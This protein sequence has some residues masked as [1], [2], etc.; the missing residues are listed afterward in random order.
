MNAP[1]PTL[2]SIA[3][4]AWAASTTIVAAEVVALAL[5]YPALGASAL[6]ELGCFALA[7]GAVLGGAA[8]LVARV[9]GEPGWAWSVALWSGLALAHFVP[10]GRAGKLGLAVFAVAVLALSWVAARIARALGERLAVVHSARAWSVGSAAAFCALAALALTRREGAPELAPGGGKPRPSVLLVT[11]DTLRADFLGCY[12]REQARTPTLDGLAASGFRFEH[13]TAHTVLTGPSHASVLTGRLPAHHG[14]FENLQPLSHEVPTVAES[15]GSLGYRTGAF[16]AGYPLKQNAAA[17]LRRFEHYDDDFRSWRTLPS[18]AFELVLGHWMRLALER[19]GEHLDPHSRSASAVTEVASTWLDASD[20]RPF[21]AWVHYFD[22]HLPYEPPRESVPD[23]VRAYRGLDGADWYRLSP[24][25]RAHI[26]AD[27]AA[28]RHMNEL[29]DAEIASVDRELARLV[30][31][32]RRGAGPNGLWI[33]V[34]ADHGESFG[35]HRIFFERDLYEDCLRVPL[36][37][38]PPSASAPR[39]IAEPVG[40]VDIAPTLLDAVDERFDGDGLSLLPLTRGETSAPRELLAEI[41]TSTGVPLRRPA[42]SVRSG[43]WKLIVRQ[44]FWDNDEFEWRPETERELYELSKDSTELTD[45]CDAEPAR[46]RALEAAAAALR[47]LEET[48]PLDLSE[49]QLQK[50]RELGYAR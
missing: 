15:F 5:R 45:R 11:I 34:T 2:G 46:A 8:T 47:R 17:M 37:V 7:C 41:F 50:L 25:E 23:D 6:F 42:F 48:G 26:V 12:G 4:T 39:T 18:E 20:A 30:D 32:A 36:I 13:A 38:V 9:R 22:P 16:V 35:E 19:S 28:L 3:R 40:L 1:S 29:Y 49:G 10:I 24:R 31:A 14:V 44:P 43:A 27:P 33:V 21:F